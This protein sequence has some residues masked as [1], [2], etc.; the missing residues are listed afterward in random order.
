MEAT[1]GLQHEL[2]SQH[3]EE[4]ATSLFKQKSNFDSLKFLSEEAFL[5]L[6]QV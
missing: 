5:E 3:R 6:G 2:P 1:A 4:K